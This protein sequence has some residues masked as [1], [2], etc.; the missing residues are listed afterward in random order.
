L[1]EVEILRLTSEQAKVLLRLL[2]ELTESAHAPTV[3]HCVVPRGVP[4]ASV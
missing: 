4:R 3:G 1:R 2:F